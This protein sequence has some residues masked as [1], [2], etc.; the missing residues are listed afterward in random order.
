M[1]GIILILMSEGSGNEYFS[2]S[3]SCKLQHIGAKNI[4]SGIFSYID[5]TMILLFQKFCTSIQIILTM[6]G[7][8]LSFDKLQPSSYNPSNRIFSTGLE[9]KLFLWGFE[10]CS[11]FDSAIFKDGKDLLNISIWICYIF[12]KFTTFIFLIYLMCVAGSCCKF[13]TGLKV[14]DKNFS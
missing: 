4:P 3:S 9:I 1:K 12:D 6:W 14:I 10:T 11:G 13:F 7:H 8:P 2:A 5:G